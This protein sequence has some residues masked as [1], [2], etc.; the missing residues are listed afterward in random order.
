MFRLSALLMTSVLVGIGAKLTPPRSV[1]WPHR[2]RL[3]ALH[4]RPVAFRA[5]TLGGDL[6]I[7][8]DASGRRTTTRTT[9]PTVRILT[10]KDT[11]RAETPAAFPLDLSKGPVVFSAEGNDSLHLVISRNP[12]GIS[13]VSAKGRQLTVRLVGDQFVID[14]R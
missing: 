9:I 14:S 11:V 7:A 8:V 6:I 13:Q 5:S 3:T 1:A 12:D 2:A 10:V 4:Q